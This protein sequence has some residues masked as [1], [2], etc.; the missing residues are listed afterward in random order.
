MLIQQSREPRREQLIDEVHNERRPGGGPELDRC[1]RG[2]YRVPRVGPATDTENA[3][4]DDRERRFGFDAGEQVDCARDVEL[5][6]QPRK[7]NDGDTVWATV[8][9]RSRAR[10]VTVSRPS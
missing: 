1:E 3:D 5:R 4:G 10:L 2:D 6:E 9:P 8:I 7:R